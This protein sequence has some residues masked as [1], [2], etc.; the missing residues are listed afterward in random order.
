MD[1]FKTN[2]GPRV[3]PSKTSVRT[4]QPPTKKSNKRLVAVLI[5]S[6]ILIVGLGTLFFKLSRSTALQVP[7]HIAG[8]LNYR[9]YYPT[10]VTTG[11]QYQADSAKIRTTILFFT[12]SNGSKR[13]FITEQAIPNAAISLS[14][15][16]QHT[17]ISVPIGQA[18]IGTGL[19]NPSVV[20][21][22]PSTL[23]ELTSNKDVTKTDIISIAQAM[24]RQN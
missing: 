16:P 24:A 4:E 18:V 19:G 13:I 5:V 11:Y 23:I 12:L 14:S 20:I 10:N 3:S 1:D 9:I 17:N 22:T 15:L 6:S 2:A 7:A 21:M 8:S